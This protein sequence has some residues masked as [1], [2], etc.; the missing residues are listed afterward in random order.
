MWC[1]GWDPGTE[2]KYLCKVCSLINSFVLMLISS[3]D[4]V[5]KLD[6]M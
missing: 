4:N 5:P 6:K 3:F 2:G 1:S